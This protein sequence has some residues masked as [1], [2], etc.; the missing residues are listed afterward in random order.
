[1][2]FPVDSTMF[3]HAMS[4]FATGVAIIG[5]RDENGNPYG[6]TVSSFA[7]LSLT[8]PLVQWSIKEQSYSWPIFDTSSHFSVT[9]LSDEQEVVSREFCQPIDRFSTVEWKWG[10]SGVPLIMGGVA[11]I[12][13]VKDQTFSGGDHRIVIG[14]VLRVQTFDGRPLVHWR[15]DY[16]HLHER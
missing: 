2:S 12:E 8:P 13:C 3:R 6:I 5:T 16:S 9:V 7:S 14:R 4:H 1:M 15:G 11:W 10:D